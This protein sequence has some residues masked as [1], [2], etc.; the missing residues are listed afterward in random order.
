M[1]KI[2]V[3]DLAFMSQDDIIRNKTK[4]L[5]KFDDGVEFPMHP[6][7]IILSWPYWALTRHYEEIRITGG[8]AY[9]YHTPVTDGQ[10]I[11]MCSLAVE[12]SR[13]VEGIDKTDVWAIV[14]GDVY[15][16]AYNLAC[17]KFARYAN[18]IDFE[19]IQ[20]LIRDPEIAEALA[21]LEYTANSV[22]DAY[23]VIER[24][25]RS[26]RYP[27][28]GI[29]LEILNK[30]VKMDQAL[31]MLIRGRTTE[32]NSMIFDRPIL[33]GFATGFKY[34]SEYAKEMTSATKSFVYND[35]YIAL[36][37]YFNRKM[38][39]LSSGL[40]H[41]VQGD[42]GTTETL[43]IEVP[44]GKS[45]NVLLERIVGAY[46]HEDGKWVLYKKPD[47]A[48]L[49]KVLKVRTTLS[50][51]ELEHQGVCEKCFGDL[52]Y[53]ITEIDSPGHVACITITEGA[54][55]GILSVKH[56]DFISWLF[57]VA[58]E[59]AQTR[60][61]L[62]R[63]APASDANKI[64]VRPDLLTDN[65]IRIRVQR[66]EVPNLVK[67]DYMKS[68]NMSQL[69]IGDISNITKYW[70]DV[71]APAD[72]TGEEVCVLSDVFNGLCQGVPASFSIEFL[73]FILRNRSYIMEEDERFISFSIK[74]FNRKDGG[75]HTPCIF[76][77]RQRHESMPAYVENLEN[78][79]RSDEKCRYKHITEYDGSTADGCAEAVMAIHTYLERKLPGTP[80]SHI[81]TLLA[82]L[83][84]NSRR[85]AGI[86]SGFHNPT[87][88]FDK[89]DVLMEDRSL[90]PYLLYENQ[91]RIYSSPRTYVTDERCNSLLDSSVFIPYEESEVNSD[92]MMLKS[93][94]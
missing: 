45:G 66:S 77:Y 11:D 88:Y 92:S 43:P 49:G 16:E 34:L 93:I 1:D 35:G 91:N 9:N 59:K 84:R 68:K 69:D 94:T 24:V 6:S 51:K 86:P 78:I 18:T 27:S 17:D 19:D 5:V 47:K 3:R 76:E 25:I 20:Q 82:S 70:V 10:H 53:N 8:L 63:S 32:V 33:G 60:Y 37:E 73:R 12:L 23:K 46:I 89:H 58:L 83:R 13:E 74:G 52:S 48:H 75:V 38:Q 14:Y 55:Q 64:F 61:F 90:G 85:D 41:L 42:C 54:S 62:T 29:V 72:D 4:Y 15:N 56:L 44:Q 36:S 65:D 31:Q 26:N 7:H 57:Q 22:T 50:C 28:N 40:T 2:H 39:L 80:I 30:T 87:A 81:A 21:G 71:Y 67:L 79:L